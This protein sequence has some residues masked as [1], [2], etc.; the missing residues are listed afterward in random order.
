ML[1]DVAEDWD[2]VMRL[3][4]AFISLL[5]NLRSTLSRRNTHSLGMFCRFSRIGSDDEFQ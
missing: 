3:T 5:I 4:K 2:S 1:L